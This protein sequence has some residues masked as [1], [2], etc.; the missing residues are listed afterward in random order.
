MQKTNTTSQQPQDDGVPAYLIY[1]GRTEVGQHLHYILRSLDQNDGKLS[2]IKKL[3][4]FHTDNK[5]YKRERIG[6]I[7]PV[8]LV[9]DG[10][11]IR[12]N[13]KANTQGF[14]ANQEDITQWR[15]SDGIY[16]AQAAIEKK[17]NDN[18]L[19]EL[20]APITEKYK[21]TYNR[22]QR[23]AILAEVISIITTA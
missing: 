16:Q 7:M 15:L 3:N 12:Y 5:V 13:D 11:S 8:T 20:L 23:A 10:A 21:T 18:P 2:A 6:Y 22:K 4:T 19:I 1:A 17:A 14:W 9:K